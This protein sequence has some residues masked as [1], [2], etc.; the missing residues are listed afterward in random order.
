MLEAETVEWE[1]VN[2]YAEQ[3]QLVQALPIACLWNFI[4][5]ESN[6]Q[7]RE[8]KNIDEL[9]MKLDAKKSI[10]EENQLKMA[11]QNAAFDAKK[12]KILNE[13]D[14]M[15]TRN[16]ELELSDEAVKIIHETIMEKSL[17]VEKAKQKA[18]D[19]KLFKNPNDFPELVVICVQQRARKKKLN[20]HKARSSIVSSTKVH[21]KHSGRIIKSYLEHEK[22]K[23]PKKVRIY[24][25]SFQP[26]ALSA[27]N[28]FSMGPNCYGNNPQFMS[29]QD[30]KMI[31][32]DSVRE[33]GD[34]D[35]DEEETNKD[36][37]FE[38][39]R[40]ERRQAKFKKVK[41]SVVTQLFSEKQPLPQNKLTTESGELTDEDTPPFDDDD[42]GME[43][44][45]LAD[46]LDLDFNMSMN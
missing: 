17:E 9:T 42:D 7:G 6:A 37:T 40:L 4:K 43:M 8:E 20:G 29:R 44:T 14:E 16:K 11:E 34:S 5:N 21:N 26:G 24:K 31:K 38:Q 3:Q 36:L 23:R 46:D 33:D 1:D 32:V 22:P 2:E 41:S 28:S 13:I 15:E 39:F 30:D 18:R 45:P 27:Q 12:A 19:E 25:K 10:Y 35:S